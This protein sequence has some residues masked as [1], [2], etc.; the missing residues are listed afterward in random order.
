MLAEV[1]YWSLCI[2][3]AFSS[4]FLWEMPLELLCWPSLGV[5]LLLSALSISVESAVRSLFFVLKKLAASSITFPWASYLI[6]LRG[7]SYL[8]SYF[9]FRSSIITWSPGYES[10]NFLVGGPVPLFSVNSL[11]SSICLMVPSSSSIFFFKK[12]LLSRISLQSS[13]L[14]LVWSLNLKRSRYGGFSAASLLDDLSIK[15]FL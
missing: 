11:K 6:I 9:V 12:P 2:L 8:K 14:Y 7:S 4:I 15:R 13:R 5:Y 1:C 3:A 10:M